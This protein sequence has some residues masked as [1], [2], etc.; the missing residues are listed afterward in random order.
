M[1]SRSRPA[2]VPWPIE[3][4]EQSIPARFARQVQAH[5]DRV[6]VK[7]GGETIT[8]AALDVAA[9]RLAHAILA[10]QDPGPAPV[11]LL[12]D[13]GLAAVVAMMGVLKAGKAYVAV[14]PGHPPARSR[15]ILDDIEAALLV[16]DSR[17][18]ARA[19]ELATRST[20]LLEVDDPRLALPDEPPEVAIDPGQLAYILYTSGST[21]LPKGAMM[22]HRGTL[23]EVLRTTSE[24]HIGPDDRHTLLRSTGFA[25]AVRDVFA[26]LLNGA[27]LHSLNLADCGIDR[28]A[29]WLFE[30]DI[31]LY[32]SVVSVFRR[33]LATL[34]GVE[35][36]PQLRV[37]HVGG[38]TLTRADVEAFQERLPETCRLLNNLATT[39]T[40][41]ARHFLI[42]RHT[43]I[44]GGAVPVGYAVPGV[45]VLLLDESGRPVDPGAQGEIAVRSRYLASGYWR[46]PELTRQRFLPDPDGGDTLTYLTG[47][48]GRMLPDGCLVHEGRKDS[49]VKVRGHRVEPAEIEHALLALPGVKEAAVVARATGDSEPTLVAYVVPA[50]LPA[51]THSFLRRGLAQVVPE[52]MLPSA[53]VV[54]DAMPLTAV[55][56]VDRLALPAPRRSRP[57]LDEPYMAPRF[58]VETAVAAIWAEAL[59]LEQVGVRD[60]FLD[61]G[62]HSLLASRIAARVTEALAVDIPMRALFEA[63]TVEAMARLV[64][65]QLASRAAEDA[66][67]GITV[68]QADG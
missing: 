9:N 19:R 2:G 11:A 23:H 39:E 16:T 68:E 66:L 38:E 21:G 5:G 30:E 47:D 32:R 3:E 48:L 52:H 18:A 42:D 27:S 54:L 57:P 41:T 20:R 7:A 56:K 33:F 8:Y 64:T 37:V 17:H 24:L 46:R 44:P 60:N 13:Q 1:E 6:A 25:G 22:T 67:G 65:E 62:G 53:F 12:L 29:S 50:S 63:S 26:T 28:L 10:G 49:Q 31:T 43:S 61:L 36:F 15:H 35:R 14:D 34:T 45:E 4:V 58:P 40:G 51:P 59:D 55:G